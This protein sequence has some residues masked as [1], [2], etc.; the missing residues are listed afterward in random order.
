MDE[1]HYTIAHCVFCGSEISED[2]VE[3]IDDEDMV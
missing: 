2:E 3:R 1:N